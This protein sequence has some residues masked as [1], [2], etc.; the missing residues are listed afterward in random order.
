MVVAING[1]GR[2]GRCVA[3]ILC[4]EYPGVLALINDPANLETLSY[5]FQHD[6]VHGL[7]SKEVQNH[8]GQLIVDHQKILFRACKDPQDLDLSGVDVLLETS[9][10]FCAPKA[11][12]VFKERGAKKVILGAPFEPHTAPLASKA[13]FVWG[14]NH[15]NYA[16]EP[17]LSNASCTTNALA[18]IC[19][20]LDRCFGIES[21]L[22]T[23]IHSYTKGQ[24]LVDGALSSDKRRS[25]AA[26]NIVPT[27]TRAAKALYLVLPN[28]EGKMHGRSVR[29]PTMD[30]SMVDLSVQLEK[31]AST[32][33]LIAL[34]K[35]A[36]QTELKGILEVDGHHKV[37][38]DIVGNA[39]SCVVVEDMLFSLGKHAKIMAWYDNEWAY[40]KRLVDM[41]FYVCG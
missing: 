20:L 41:A 33:E 38:S 32:G 34:F 40:A 35:E 15:K 24:A 36:S 27:T 17:I 25:R 19:M 11:L 30:V 23:T 6:S 21:A 28:L 18:P 5:L 10:H 13:T 22:L 14:V 9:G 8:K 3:R 31:A 16:N 7:Y 26:H 29:V 1:F 39:A 37:S 4:A 2:I 12:E